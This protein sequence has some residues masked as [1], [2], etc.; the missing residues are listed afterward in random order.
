MEKSKERQTI[1]MADSYNSGLRKRKNWGS[2]EF[3]DPH[4]SRS[5]SSSV[6]KSRDQQLPEQRSASETGKKVVPKEEQN[7]GF[8]KRF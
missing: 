5:E 8:K 6:T 7:T 2:S 4:E 3:T 1:S